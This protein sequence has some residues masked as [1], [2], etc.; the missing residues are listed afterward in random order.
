MNKDLQAL[1]VNYTT[2]NDCKCGNKI[3]YTYNLPQSVDLKILKYLEVLGSS[4]T[5][6]Q[7]QAILKIDNDK[8]TITAIKRFKNIKLV[9]K[10]IEYNY[11]IEQF[12]DALL[13]WLK[14]I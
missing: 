1:G 9:I 3:S 7:K 4:S 13:S 6:L 10:N 14:G 11:I 5:S 12:E 8:I 2:G